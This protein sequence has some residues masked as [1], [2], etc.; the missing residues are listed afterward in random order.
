HLGRLGRLLALL[1]L[2]RWLAVP[3]AVVVVAVGFAVLEKA[4][5][6]GIVVGPIVI[7][8]VIMAVLGLVWPQRP[9]PAS[10]A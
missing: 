1:P 8:A 6:L 5:H 3:G 7:G 4:T 10:P 9:I 2:P